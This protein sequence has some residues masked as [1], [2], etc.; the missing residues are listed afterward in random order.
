MDV[1]AVINQKGGVAK[2]TTAH[3]IAA[4]LHNRGRDVIMVDMDAQ[5]SLSS[6]LGADRNRVTI[7]DV[8]LRKAKAA[9]AIQ[10]AG[11]LDI[12]ASSDDMAAEGILTATGKEFR[13]REALQALERPGSVIIIDCPPSLG[14]LTINAL[15]AA[16]SILIPCQA[17]SLSLE[18]LRQLQPTI[19]TIKRYTNPSLRLSGVLL[20]RYNGRA[21]LSREVAEMIEA[22]AAKMGTKVFKTRIREGIAIKEAQ[23]F[24]S[25]IFAYDPKSNGAKDYDALLDEL[26][27]GGK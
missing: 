27:K 9:Q 14:I 24:H 26:E 2:T 3:N 12:I 20:T 21:V 1:I 19:D 6:I 10:R 7:L 22:E 17:D 8:L 25:D 5:G 4:G 23:A 13:L 16:T 15:T 11:T 18:A